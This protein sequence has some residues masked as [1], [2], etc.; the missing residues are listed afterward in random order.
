MIGVFS[1][2]GN[3][4]TPAATPQHEFR[5]SGDELSAELYGYPPP[6]PISPQLAITAA[7][8]HD[9]QT[10]LPSDMNWRSRAATEDEAIKRAAARSSSYAGAAQ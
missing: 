4:S 2:L 9:L 10:R 6:L 5:G 3:S 7:T 1:I 8:L